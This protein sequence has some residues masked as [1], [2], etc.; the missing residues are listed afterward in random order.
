MPKRIRK[1]KSQDPSQWAYQIVKESVEAP[2]S[3]EQVSKIMSA[4]GRKGGKIGGKR[5]L[6]TMTAEERSE[7][8]SHAARAK[9]AKV[10]GKK[11]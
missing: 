8:A 2:I 1:R 7:A 9:W 10:N 4:M 11:R 6:E 5:R 3:S